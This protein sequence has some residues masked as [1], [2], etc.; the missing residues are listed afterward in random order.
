MTVAEATTG[1]TMIDETYEFSAPRFFDF[2]NGE[3]MEEARRAELWFDTALSYAPSPFMPKIKASRS[4]I[5]ESLC[6]FGEADNMEKTSANVDDSVLE[7]NQQPQS[8]TTE[9]KEDGAPCIEAQEENSTTA[10]VVSACKKDDDAPCSKA[11]EEI[12]STTSHV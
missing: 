10:P 5:V 1:A 9:I 11:K 8:T 6:D 4:I 7:T 12:H 3:S 2:I